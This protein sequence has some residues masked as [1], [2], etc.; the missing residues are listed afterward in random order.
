MFVVF[1]FVL[2]FF[3]ELTLAFPL[4]Y[5]TNWGRCNRTCVIDSNVKNFVKLIETF[6]QKII[7]ALD[8][9]PKNSVIKLSVSLNKYLSILTYLRTKIKKICSIQM[10]GDNSSRQR[11]NSSVSG[12]F[13]FLFF[14]VSTWK[15]GFYRYVSFLRFTSDRL[16][17]THPDLLEKLASKIT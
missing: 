6:G 8:K 4:D 1:C 10:D 7:L 16:P 11:T 3:S 17:H 13:V 14:C 12:F 5:V 15:N 2:S 9:W